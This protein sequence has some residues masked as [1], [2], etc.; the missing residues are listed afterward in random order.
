MWP[1]T[2]RKGSSVP[3]QPTW[4]TALPWPL[5]VIDF[6]AISLDLNGYPIEVGLAVWPAPEEPI[7]GWVGADP[8]GRGLDAARPLEPASAEAHGIRWRAPGRGRP[9]GRIALALNEVLGPDCVIWCD[10]GPYDAQ[11]ARALFRAGGVRPLFALG[12]WHRLA[13]MLGGPARKRALDWLE[14]APAGHRAREDAEQALFALAH[15]AGVQLGPAQDL[16]LH[17]PALSAMATPAAELPPRPK[18]ATSSAECAAPAS[19]PNSLSRAQR[20][21]WH[22]N[23]PDAAIMMI[24]QN[25]HLGALNAEPVRY[26]TDEGRLE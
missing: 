1:E 14:R 13:H 6:E 22:R 5:H 24:G 23:S 2:P 17:R 25:R 18:A 21:W 26:E 12:D 4:R 10:G 8:P 19:K 3:I 7:L 11:W 20:P 9:P 15:A 16:D